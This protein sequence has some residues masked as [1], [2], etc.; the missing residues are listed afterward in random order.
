[1]EEDIS[2]TT[3]RALPNE[4]TI[5]IIEYLDIADVV[6]FVLVCKKFYIPVLAAEQIDKLNELH[7]YHDGYLTNLW[8]HNRWTEHA[9]LTRQ[10]YTWLGRRCIYHGQNIGCLEQPRTKRQRPL[11]LHDNL[12]SGYTIDWPNYLSIIELR[13]SA[14]VR[15]VE[16][17]IRPPEYL[18]V[19]SCRQLKR[20]FSSFYPMWRN[21]ECVLRRIYPAY[22]RQYG[23]SAALKHY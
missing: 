12:E 3:L 10:L 13:L 23:H 20:L 22:C 19:R 7:L 8:H 17:I 16:K 1:M 6:C 9:D 14:M 15:K 4:I 5:T 21:P 18:G 2:L 11:L